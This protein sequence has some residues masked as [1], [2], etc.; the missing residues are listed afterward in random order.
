MSVK[1]L[2][3]G[4]R[5]AL[6]AE[7]VRMPMAHGRDNIARLFYDK[8]YSTAIAAERAGKLPP[9][10]IIAS[11]LTDLRAKYGVQK[12]EVIEFLSRA[13]LKDAPN[14]LSQGEIMKA[15]QEIAAGRLIPPPPLSAAVVE[16]QMQRQATRGME[17]EVI[18]LNAYNFHQGPHL[19]FVRT[20]GQWYA[21]LDQVKNGTAEITA[22]FEGAILRL[23]EQN[24]P[25]GSDR[26]L[27]YEYNGQQWTLHFVPHVMADEDEFA[28]TAADFD[29][30]AY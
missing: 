2:V 18:T 25:E 12:T 11:C 3:D 5:K 4:V 16:Q 17:I 20:G 6:E 15:S 1:N 14:Q 13:F 9:P 28:Y 22:Q 19:N 21:L 7:G 27:M 30:G 10:Q 24:D 8:S 23:R 29:D 26:F